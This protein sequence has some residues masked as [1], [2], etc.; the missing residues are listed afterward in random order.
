MS[1]KV[2][3]MIL[4]QGRPTTTIAVGDPLTFRL[5]SQDGYSHAT[6]IFATNVVARDPYSGRSV[7][8]IDNYGCPVDNLVFP[9]LGR[10][11]DNDALEARFNAFKIPESN[12]LVFEATVRTCRGG[13]QPAYCPGPSGRSEPSFGRRKRSVSE[14]STEFDGTAEPLVGDSIEND[15]EVAIVNGTLMNDNRTDKNSTNAGDE[16]SANDLDSNGNEM[17]EHVREMIEVFQSREEMQ[18]DTVARK[19]VAPQEAV[20][21]TNS[22]YYGL[23]SALILLMILLVSIT[24]ASGLAYRRYWKIFLKNRS[25][26]RT[27]PVNSFTPSALHNVSG[28]QFHASGRGNSTS[29]R[30]DARTPGLSLFGTGLQKT[31]ATGN[32][33]RMCQIPV[34]NPMSRSNGSKNEFDDPSEPIYTDPSLFER[35]RSLRSIAVDQTDAHNV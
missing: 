21:L 23:L 9:E 19:M 13:C 31:F 29:S 8:L 1:N 5:E 15:D 34:M 30:C 27:S 25:L 22:E 28:S 12:F 10:S 6:D 7:Q 14:E 17:P 4:Y 2:R 33:S 18:Q 3:L 32:L 24:F 26:D 11:R 16:T 20:C 35:S